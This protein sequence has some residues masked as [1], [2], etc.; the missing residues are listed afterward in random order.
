MA[1]P[2]AQC[3]ATTESLFDANRNGLLQQNLLIP[4]ILD[5]ASL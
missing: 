4:D 2:A 5:T 3:G 1:N